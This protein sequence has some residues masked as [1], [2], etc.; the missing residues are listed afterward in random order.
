MRLSV[1]EH[2]AR[3]A[4]VETENSRRASAP[5]SKYVL[6]EGPSRSACHLMYQPN[7]VQVELSSKTTPNFWGLDRKA[8]FSGSGRPQPFPWMDLTIVPHNLKRAGIERISSW[9]PL[10]GRY[11]SKAPTRSLQ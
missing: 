2:Q 4:R 1:R 11:A 3:R 10:D 5:R 6:H 7:V 8:R 9:R